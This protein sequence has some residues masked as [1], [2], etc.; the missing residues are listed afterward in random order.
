MADPTTEARIKAYRQ[1]LEAARRTIEL[2]PRLDP[3]DSRAAARVALDL[4]DHTLADP[5]YEHSRVGEI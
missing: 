5:L 2:L 1:T 3:P 4:I